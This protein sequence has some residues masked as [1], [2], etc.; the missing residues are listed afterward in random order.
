MHLNTIAIDYRKI[1]IEQSYAV[2]PAI[3]FSTLSEPSAI[4]YQL[5]NHD[6][7]KTD[8]IFSFFLLIKYSNV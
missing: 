2:T 6:K 7:S 3:S 4:P 1:A 5:I 8:S